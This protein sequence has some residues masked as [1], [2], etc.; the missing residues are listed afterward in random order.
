[1]LKDDAIGDAELVSSIGGGSNEDSAH[2]DA[3]AGNAVVT[4][5][6]AQHLARAAGEIEDPIPYPWLEGP[7]QHRQLLLAERIM[8]PVMPFPD[9]MLAG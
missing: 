3:G 5:P 4:G 8:N 1:M 7:A 6:G 9:D 2:I